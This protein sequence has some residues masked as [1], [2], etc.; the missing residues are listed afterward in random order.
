MDYSDIKN[1]ILENKYI[2]EPEIKKNVVYN[3]QNYSWIIHCKLDVLERWMSIVIGIPLNWELHLFDFYFNGEI[4]FIPHIDKSGKLCLFEL[5]GKLIYPDFEGLLNQCILRAKELITDGILGKNKNDFIKE[6]DSYFGLLKD[7]LIAH[8]VLPIEK[9]H[10]NIKFCEKESKDKL[11]KREIYFASI[12]QKDFSIWGHRGTQKNGIYFYIK[13]SEYIFPPN[14]FNYNLNEFL[15][16][17]LDFIDLESL[18]KLRSKCK[19][20]L[21]LIFEIQQDEKT[22]NSCGFIIEN[23]N[24]SL[25]D[26]VKLVSF[27]RITPLLIHRVDINYLSSR[28]SFSSN[29]LSNKSI[30]L[31]GCGSIGGY[32][33][34]NLIKSGCKN[35]T[36]V[37]DDIM[38]PENV[39]RHFL[40]VESS[41]I[42][43]AKSLANYAKNTLPEIEVKIILKKIEN[44]IVD[45]DIDFNTFDYIVSAIGNHTINC[46]LNKYML[47][48]KILK[49]VFYIWNEPLDIG[50][51]IVRINIKDKNDYRDIFSIVDNE[52][53]D[54]SSYVKSGQTFTKTYSGCNGT[55]IPYGSILSIESS[56]LLMD[57]LKRELVGK[58]KNNTIISKKEDDYYFNKAGFL[59][60]DR[61]ISQKEK[62]L[63]I[64]LCDLRKDD[65]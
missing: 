56:T 20:K 39:F 60:S 41:Y 38:K 49:T 14:I 43:K 32:V 47:E 17:L 8:V 5:E 52:I 57:L 21:V 27:N 4:P 28:I 63:E 45:G 26:K 12:N 3:G 64:A 53:L 2:S 50:C 6:F 1:I 25:K 37:D 13:P 55:F 46:W 51:H 48:K 19:N 7:K 29:E 62:Y 35:I 30:L 15:N 24:F 65:E 61:Y 42:Y 40:G 11:E 16:K 18:K 36:L 59:V 23:P 58:V 44:A 10:I 34:H 9:K 33:F 54:L 31:I 22:T